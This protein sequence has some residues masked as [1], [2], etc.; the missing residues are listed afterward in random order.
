MINAWF[1]D[2]YNFGDVFNR[3]LIEKLSGQEVHCV[4]IT[5]DYTKQ[6]IYACCGS[7]L[8]FLD[9]PCVVWGAGLIGE[10]FHI[11]SKPSR[12]IAVRGPRTRD[13]LLRRG[14]WCPELFGDP[15]LLMP[16][17]YDIKP[18]PRYELGIVPHYVDKISEFLPPPNSDDILIIDVKKDPLRVAS[19]IVKCKR[20]IS[21]SLHGVIAADAFGIPS[22]WV[23]MSD[24][25]KG[26]GFKFYDYYES[27]GF[28]A[29]KPHKIN[30]PTNW[31][32]LSE[33]CTYHPIKLDT[34]ALLNSCP[35]LKK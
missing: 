23:E 29:P 15:G 3:D 6:P 9:T 21:S 12:V 16:L 20:I 24:L 11:K 7:L 10:D 13:E 33:E 8:S 14:I 34:Q 5:K 22:L 31:I 35:F 27:I 18:E 4:E 30:R 2:H 32:R 26:K 19:N 25:V 28:S 17:I 1:F